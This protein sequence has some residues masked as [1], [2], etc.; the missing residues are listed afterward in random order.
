[1]KGRLDRRE[2]TGRSRLDDASDGDRDRILVAAAAP[3]SFV[4]Q[5]VYEFRAG[6]KIFAN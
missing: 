4:R 1:M 5:N 2:K 6:G 3:R